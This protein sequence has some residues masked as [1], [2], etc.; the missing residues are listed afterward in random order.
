MYYSRIKEIET[1]LSHMTERKK[2]LEKELAELKEQQIKEPELPRVKEAF[3]YNI[4]IDNA[5]IYIT[6]AIEHFDKVDNACYY[7]NNYFPGQYEDFTLEVA[8]KIKFILFLARQK[9]MYCPDWQPD[10]KPDWSG[11]TNKEK[12]YMIFF[13][14]V[15]HQYYVD[16]FREYQMKESIYF[17]TEEIAQKVCDKLNAQLRN[18]GSE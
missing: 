9:M 3:Y 10:W 1:E 16:Y 4:G 7:G 14:T 18:K 6:S 2:V 8:E 17:P 15:T 13:N 11:A 12:K 5:D